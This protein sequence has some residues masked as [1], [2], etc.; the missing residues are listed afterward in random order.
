MKELNRK[1]AE[2]VRCAGDIILSA[3]DVENEG[4]VSEKHG[5]AANM[6]TKYDVAVQEFLMRE[7]LALIPEASFIAEEKENDTEALNRPYCFIIDPIDGTANFVHE[8]RHSCISLALISHGVAEF[9]AVYD[10]YQREMFCAERGGGA[11]LNDRPMHVSEREC[12]HSIVTFGTSPYYKSDLGDKTFALCKKLFYITNDMRRSGS[13]ALDLAY[14]AA[15]RTDM[16]FEFILSPWDYAAGILLIEEA[17]GI[18]SD[19][20]GDKLIPSEPSSVI[21][22]NKKVYDTLLNLTKLEI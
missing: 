13:A 10:P 21:A 22:A 20:Q 16:F 19:M 4:S 6:V 9:A 17:G 18:I 11:F 14:L 2:L 15:G 3:H 12:A 1:I 8:F 7:I 5:D